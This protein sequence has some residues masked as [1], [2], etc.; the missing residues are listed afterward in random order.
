MAMRPQ[1]DQGQQAAALALIGGVPW[2]DLDALIRDMETALRLA[3]EATADDDTR[4]ENEFW[5]AFEDAGYDEFTVPAELIAE[6]SD[7]Q[8]LAYVARLTRTLG[9]LYGGIQWQRG[10]PIIGDASLET[11]AALLRGLNDISWLP[12]TESQKPQPPTIVV[13]VPPR[14]EWAPK[15]RRR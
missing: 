12:T 1:F 11:P 13:H 3:I 4:W 6:M 7:E 8:R 9:L 15:G 2:G 10:L 14:R 5:S